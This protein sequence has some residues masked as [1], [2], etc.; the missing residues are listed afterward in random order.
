MHLTKHLSLIILSS[1]L[2]VIASAQPIAPIVGA[3]TICTYASYSYGNS[4]L[5]E[6]TPSGTWS[7]S[8]SSVAAIA[9]LG[10]DS[11]AISGISV[12]VTTVTYTV[13]ASYVT[14]TIT[15]NPLPA[16]FV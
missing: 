7:I 2:P 14:A 15:V 4:I 5:S 11:V 3:R 16:A 13:G 10:A 8:S 1:I 12:G 9:P 6:T